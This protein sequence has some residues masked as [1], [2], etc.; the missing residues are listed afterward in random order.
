MRDAQA[1]VENFEEGTPVLAGGGFNA[2]RAQ[3]HDITF[4]DPI[5]DYLQALAGQ[6][7]AASLPNLSVRA[8][9]QIKGLAQANAMI[10]GR[11]Y[12]LPEDVQAVFVPALQH[13]LGPVTGASADFLTDILQQVAAP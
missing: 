1:G 10:G 2:L 7:R 13:R 3:C 4:A 9:I 8:L 12:C 5:I 11:D 6:L